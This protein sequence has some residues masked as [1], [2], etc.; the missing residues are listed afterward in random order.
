MKRVFAAVI[1]AALLI[2][3]LFS[4]II[5]SGNLSTVGLA[6]PKTISKVQSGLI[7]SDPLNGFET[8]QQLQSNGSYWQYGGTGTSNGSY[9][10]FEAANK[11][12]IGVSGQANG[13][14]NGYYAVTP[15][16][17]ASLVH[18][19]LSVSNA[20]DAT[21]YSDTGLY[22]SASNQIL[23]YVACL[24]VTTPTGTVWGVVHAQSYSGANPVITPLWVDG[25]KNQPL[26]GD[27]AMMTNGLNSL[28]VYLNHVLVFQSSDLNL[29][30][31]APYSFYVEEETSVASSTVYA[32][33]QDFYVTLGGTVTVTGLP[34]SAQS[35]DLVG[36]SG[37]VYATA[38]VAGSKAVLNVGNYTYPLEGRINA[39]ST[40]TTMGH[41]NSSLVA[42]SSGLQS[43]YGGDAYAFGSR[44]SSTVSLS[45]QAQDLSGHD[46]SGLAVI[47]VQN[48]QTIGNEYFPYQFNLNN[49]QTYT[50]TAYD[51]GSY[52]FDH[53]SDG[54]TSRVMTFSLSKDTTLTAYYRNVAAAAPVGKSIITVT[55]V[56]STGKPLTGLTS[57]LWLNG[58]N[59]GL[60]YTPSSFEVNNGPIY[61]V[62]AS[63]FG[64][65]TFSHWSNGYTQS[66]YPIALGGST[67]NLEAIYTA[68]S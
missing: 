56:D 9:T 19:V 68:N 61:Y 59:V 62:A 12:S 35:V 22:M 20:S 15:P 32:N 27:C 5:L 23:N 8:Q 64:G 21:G 63:S 2:G 30:M 28:S 66:F 48:H 67:L 33:Y 39:Y 26:T 38:A 11:L 54:S 25:S 49:S 13:G 47:V 36:A 46:L 65:Y 7:A 24:A 18:A 50:V 44:P 3:S 10:F 31:P 41:P 1:I 55:A 52:T 37:N 14:W 6:P 45:L 17:N 40:G 57:T 43:V 4:I 42:A 16:T 34:S 53:W 60:T 58:M 29:G 51:Y